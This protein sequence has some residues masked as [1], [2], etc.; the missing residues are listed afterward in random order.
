MTVQCAGC[1]KRFFEEGFKVDR[2]GRHL[3]TCLECNIR[4]KARRDS[5]KC[6]HG[7]QRINCRDCGGAGFCKHEHLRSQCRICSPKSCQASVELRN[8]RVYQKRAFWP[9][10]GNDDDDYNMKIYDIVVAIQGA[11]FTKLHEEGRVR[12]DEYEELMAKRKDW[13][14]IKIAPEYIELKASL[15]EWRRARNPPK[16]TDDKLTELIG[17]A[18]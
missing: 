2:L 5:K 14:Q 12:Q 18:L 17:F 6:E 1:K 10:F 8:F 4:D 7:R 3:K 13:E 15:K 11:R 16:F 9:W